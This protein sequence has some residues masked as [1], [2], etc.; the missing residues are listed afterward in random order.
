MAFDTSDQPPV[1][2]T[3]DAQS[4]AHA[5]PLLSELAR[6]ALQGNLGSFPPPGSTQQP[7]GPPPDSQPRATSTTDLSYGKMVE[8]GAEK[9]EV[10]HFHDTAEEGIY[11]EGSGGRG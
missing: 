3:K 6:R 2:D 9:P 1:P 8:T 5:S 10:K 11:G 4:L 7:D